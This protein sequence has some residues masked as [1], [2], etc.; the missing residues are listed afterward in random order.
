MTTEVRTP[1]ISSP[2]ELSG[3][4]LWQKQVLKFGTIWYTDALTGKRRKI[5]FD[6]A[7]GK[8]LVDAFKA[9]AYRQVP[10]Q[11]ADGQN[12]HNN[13]PRNTAG[14]VVGVQLS[15]DGSGVDGFIRTWGDGTRVVEQNPDL[16]VSARLFENHPRPDGRTFP[17]AMQHVLATV[18]PQMA[19]MTPWKRVDSVDLANGAG[20]TVLDLSAATYER[21]GSVSGTEEKTV[22]ELS[23]AE[24]RR[25]K[26]IL[27][28]DEALEALAAEL[29]DDFLAQFENDEVDETD[30]D[31]EDEVDLDEDDDEEGIELSG[32]HGEALELANAQIASQ[33]AQLLELT[34]QLSA[35]RV[36]AEVGEY[37]RHNLAPAVLDAARPLLQMECGAIEL[38]N[39]TPGQGVD[40]GQVIRDVLDNVIQLSGTGHL[41]VDADEV[42]SLQG[43]KAQTEREALLADWESYDA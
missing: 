17:V 19:D 41:F 4:G 37:R 16:G 12:R 22:L 1:F 39:G 3:G 33:G 24:A 20:G 15:A 2:V 6:S 31:V 30:T 21:S 27:E 34:N 42:G 23:V 8:Q 38:S 13:D 40:P 29:G 9:G 32:A 14:E 25:L 11:L 43:T 10:F 18:D 7:Y 36:D 28:D 5:T 26:A 35:Q